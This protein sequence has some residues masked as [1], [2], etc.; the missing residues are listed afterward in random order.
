MRSSCRSESPWYVPVGSVW[1]VGEERVESWPRDPYSLPSHLL[2][3]S[4][5]VGARAG[6]W[7][8]RG[9]GGEEGGRAGRGIWGSGRT[10]AVLV[11][12]DLP[13]LGTDLVTALTA[14]NRNE[15]T[16]LPVAKEEGLVGES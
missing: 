13:E 15:L 8:T 1:G 5:G 14:L 11:G 16:H 6:P 7:G 2:T 4:Q 3:L 9:G 10:D 12:D